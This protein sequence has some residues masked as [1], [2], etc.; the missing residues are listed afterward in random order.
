[1]Q[2]LCA[3]SLPPEVVKQFAPTGTLRAAINHGNPLLATRDKDTG[4]LRGVAIDLS[5]ELAKRLGVPLTLVPFDAAGK[6]TA[7]VKDNVWDIA[8]LGIDPARAQEIDY[9]AAYIELEGTYLVPSGSKLRAID[10]VDHE[11]VRISVTAKSAYDLYLSRVIQ[12]AQLV[13]AASTPESIDLFAAEKLDAVAGVKTALVDAAKRFPGSRVLPGHF[14]T[15]PQASGV[16]KGRPAAAKYLA[17]FI[18][19]MKASGF[20][21]AALK[22][23]GLTPDDAVVAPPAR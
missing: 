21:A 6:M 16:P 8:W 18:E 7:V 4:E 19:E 12:K 2:Q 15:I 11:G 14:M 17:D 22:R 13:R 23:D 10:D 20:V 1:M 9:S 3:Q 5:R